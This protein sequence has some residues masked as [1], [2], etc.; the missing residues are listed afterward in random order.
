MVFLLAGGKL[1]PVPV[2]PGASDG[3]FTEIVSGEL[4]EGDPVVTQ[5]APTGPQAK[6]SPAAGGQGNRMMFR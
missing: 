6:T 4:K 2:R 3:A 5:V 1:K